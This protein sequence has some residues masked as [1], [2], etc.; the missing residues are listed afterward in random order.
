LSK[1]QLGQLLWAA[2]GKSIDGVSGPTRTSASAGGIY[3]V[4]AYVVVGDV[5]DLASGVYAYEWRGHELRRI[6]DDDVRRPLADAALGQRFIAEAPVVIV[7]AADY[8]AT[9]RKY[10]SRGSERYVHMDAGHAAQNVLLQATADALGGITVGAF[11]DGPVRDLLRIEYPPLYLI[12][13][14]VPR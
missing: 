2:V 5:R 12:P 11:R 10:G 13:I 8:A 3:P 7:L 14:G 9:A 6:R 4:R 1:A